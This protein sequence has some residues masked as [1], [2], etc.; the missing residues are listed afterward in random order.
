MFM[1]WCVCVCVCVCVFTRGYCIR[2]RQ[3]ISPRCIS[4]SSERERGR[5][6]KVICDKLMNYWAP[7]GRQTFLKTW[8]THRDTCIL[9]SR[10][11]KSALRGEWD[12]RG[13]FFSPTADVAPCSHLTQKEHENTK[14]STIWNNFPR[15][16]VPV[17]RRLSLWIL[18]SSACLWKW[19]LHPAV[20]VNVCVCVC[21]CAPGR[22]YTCF[23]QIFPPWHML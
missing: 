8:L 5:E 23:A 12:H 4:E 9:C 13:G 21:V 17:G 3:H 11:S 1:S 6:K 19:R 18:I 10:Q 16:S 20:S 14:M 22:D 2:P 15:P 7:A